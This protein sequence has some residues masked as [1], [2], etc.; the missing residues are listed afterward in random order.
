MAF[1]RAFEGTVSDLQGE[2]VFLFPQS[3]VDGSGHE[4]LYFYGPFRL[5]KEDSVSSGAAPA[6]EGHPDI[7][8]QFIGSS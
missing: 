6:S 4:F 5:A 2:F 8:G 1:Y 3:N 7:D